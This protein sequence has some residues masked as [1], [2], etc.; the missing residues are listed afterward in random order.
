[1]WWSSLRSAA[2]LLPSCGVAWPWR[3]MVL[4]GR[5][6]RAAL[7]GSRLCAAL[8]RCVCSVAWRSSLWHWVP[9]IFT[10][11][12]VAVGA[13]RRGRC[14]HAVLCGHCLRTALHGHR[15]HAALCGSH[16][17]GITWRS[18]SRGI[19]W[20]LSSCS[21]ALWHLRV[22]RRLSLHG[23]CLRVALGVVVGALSSS[24]WSSSLPEEQREG[25]PTFPRPANGAGASCTAPVRA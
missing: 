3:C 9:I 22:A 10:Q 8:R 7:H 19:V 11:R 15:L 6:L 16:L 1:M 12:G 21:V 20:Q 18:S 13:V 17:C 23:C 25:A 4:R 2:W 5:C 14:L 24:S